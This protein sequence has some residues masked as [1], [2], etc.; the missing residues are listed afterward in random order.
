MEGKG[1]LILRGSGGTVPEQ[2]IGYMET[3]DPLQLWGSWIS[4]STPIV[5][6][7]KSKA[8]FLKIP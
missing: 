4:T 7:K 1:R 5:R 3:A 6:R 8:G 2:K